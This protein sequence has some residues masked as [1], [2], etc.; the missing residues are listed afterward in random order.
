MIV[1]D[2]TN[3]YNIHFSKLV[4]QVTPD[5]CSPYFVYSYF[6]YLSDKAKI[7]KYIYF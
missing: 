6:G 2:Q 7:C 3:I 5:E 4:L 1:L